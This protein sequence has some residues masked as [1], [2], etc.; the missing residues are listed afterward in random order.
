MVF[1]LQ[2]SH[3]EKAWIK[4][5][6]NR[7]FF[8]KQDSDANYYFFTTDSPYPLKFFELASRI[9]LAKFADNY[10]DNI[11]Q[12]LSAYLGVDFGLDKHAWINWW[13]K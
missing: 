8:G 2:L 13:P 3:E 10:G 6:Y 1:V 5:N 11:Y 9:D 4:E 7:F 12:K